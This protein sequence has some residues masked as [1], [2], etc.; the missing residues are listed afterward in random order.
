MEDGW[1]N[2]N[3]DLEPK[4]IPNIKNSPSNAYDSGPKSKAKLF[5]MVSQSDIVFWNGSLGVIEHNFYK[6]SSLEMVEFLK[7]HPHIKTIIGGG[8]TGSIVNDKSTE[9]N[10][11]VSTGGG[12]LL[13]YLENQFVN[14][15]NT[16]GIKIYEFNK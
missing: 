4:Y 12:A 11:Y 15:T 6:N 10:I 5:D 9:S 16:P 3:L 7:S 13:E 14:G 1:G 2:V 8:E